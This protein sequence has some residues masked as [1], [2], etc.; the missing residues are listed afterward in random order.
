MVF[1]REAAAVD[2]I[3]ADAGIGRAGDETGRPARFDL[4][5]RHAEDEMAAALAVDAPDGE[6]WHRRHDPGAADQ[7]DIAE[8]LEAVFHI[9]D[10]VFQGDAGAE[11]ELQRRRPMR[12][13]QAVGLRVADGKENVCKRV[14]ATFDHTKLRT[15]SGCF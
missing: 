4:R 11:I 8:R 2:Q 14:R 1:A 6:I 7:A 13:F 9:K 3:N 10:G 15:R 12:Q 5:L